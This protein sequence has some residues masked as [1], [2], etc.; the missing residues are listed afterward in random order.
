MENPDHTVSEAALHGLQQILAVRSALILPS[1]IPK[2]STPPLTPFNARALA[3]IAEVSKEAFNQ[4]LGP[5]VP[6]LVKRI[7]GGDADVSEAD[8]QQ[9]ATA[10]QRILSSLAG[11]GLSIAFTEIF[12]FLQENNV[13]NFFHLMTDPSPLCDKRILCRMLAFPITYSLRSELVLSP[14]W[15]CSARTPR[16]HSRSTSRI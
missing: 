13:R 9:L 6:I 16:T 14:C 11:R 3:S 7:Y 4:F 2:L 10:A 1:I 12:K 8:V 15:R 5:I